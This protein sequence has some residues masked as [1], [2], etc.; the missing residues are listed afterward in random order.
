VHDGAEHAAG[1]QQARD[2]GRRGG[3]VAVLDAVLAGDQM[4][5][6][7]WQAG[8]F[9]WRLRMETGSAATAGVR[10][11]CVTGSILAASTPSIDALRPRLRARRSASS[12]T[13][14]LPVARSSTRPPSGS[15]STSACQK[16]ASSPL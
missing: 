13:A 1:N 3:Q 11:A 16:A 2:L 6:R 12:A 8:A 15:S 14:P 5:G 9:E 7:G 10:P 4:V